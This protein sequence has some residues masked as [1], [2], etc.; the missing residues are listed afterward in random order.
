[1]RGNRELELLAELAAMESRIGEIKAE[2]NGH[3]PNQ[4]QKP[5]KPIEEGVRIQTLPQT[6]HHA[7]PNDDEFVALEV[8]VL[9]EYRMLCPATRPD[10]FS[11]DFRKAFVHIAGLQRAEKPDGTRAVSWWLDHLAAE[12]RGSVY[13]GAYIAAVIAQGD[14]GFIPAN[15]HAGQGWEFALKPYGGGRPAIAAW[16]KVLSGKLPTPLPGRM[17]QPSPAAVRLVG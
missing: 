4:Q 13:G 3:S 17:P 9:E 1:M 16:R 14:V 15:A 2:L 8:G 11:R 10:E 5:A 7:L 12:D 6:A